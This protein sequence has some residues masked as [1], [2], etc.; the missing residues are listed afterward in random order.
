MRCRHPC[1]RVITVPFGLTLGDL[2]IKNDVAICSSADV[3]KN[4]EGER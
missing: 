4:L 2:F 1:V 3:A